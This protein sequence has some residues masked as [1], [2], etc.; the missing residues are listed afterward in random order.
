MKDHSVPNFDNFEIFIKSFEYNYP[1]KGAVISSV[2]SWENHLQY[3]KKEILENL[4]ILSG[5]GRSAYL[6]RI[7]LGCEELLPR[8]Y[9]PF[10]ALEKW[11]QEY[12]TSLKEAIDTDFFSDTELHKAL[13]SEPETFK[14]SLEQDIPQ[15]Y[16]F[17]RHDFYNYFYGDFLRSAITFVDE[18]DVPVQQSGIEN[19]VTSAK[20]KSTLNVGQLS[21]LF[22]LLMEE[23]LLEYKHKTDVYRFIAT[24]FETKKA[25]IISTDSIKN[26]MDNPDY[27]NIDV[28]QEKILHILQAIK[29]DKENLGR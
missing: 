16:T 10:E 2:Y 21:Y 9:V 15:F 18:Q 7:R 24:N 8:A 19:L 4:I 3:L 22:K 27:K 25:S 23:G 14:E 20:L 12:D 1:Y 13:I 5:S 11:L 26:Q 29:K 28:M 17:A 6:K